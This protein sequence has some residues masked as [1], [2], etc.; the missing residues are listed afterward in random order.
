LEHRRDR[1]LILGYGAIG[2]ALARTLTGIDNGNDASPHSND[3]EHTEGQP[4]FKWNQSQVHV[5]DRDPLRC[6]AARQHGFIVL[7]QQKQVLPVDQSDG[8]NASTTAAI[9]YEYDYIIGCSGRQSL[10]YDDLSLVANGATLVSA[11]SGAIEFPFADFVARS[12]STVGT[13]GD[14]H[15]LDSHDIHQ[16]V[17]FTLPPVATDTTTRKN[18][19]VVNGGMPV[20]FIGLL[21]PIT[22]DKISGTIAAMIS[23]AIQAVRHHQH[24][25]HASPTS[26]SNN[27]AQM[28]AMS[29]APSR[30]IEDRFRVIEHQRR[31]L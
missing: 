24:Q 3:I 31:W 16:N 7:D 18:I 14:H 21:N 4:I 30:W 17:V 11:S 19:T 27:A 22:P 20:T 1:V 6:D 10:G 12:H 13:N 25:V 26:S 5:W 28:V 23:A 15:V 2:A 8:I 29:D 9:R